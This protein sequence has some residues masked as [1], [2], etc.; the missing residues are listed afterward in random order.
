MKG[1]IING[2]R[3]GMIAAIMVASAGTALAQQNVH[4]PVPKKAPEIG[5]NGSV[6]FRIFAPNAKDVKLGGNLS[7]LVSRGMS[8]SDGTDEFIIDSLAPGLYD[9]WFE[10][11]GVKTLD[12]A[13]S[14]VARDIASLSNIFIVPGGK[15]DYFLSSDVPHGN[16][17]K[18]WYHSPTLG[19]DRRMTIYTPAGYETSDE[20]YPVLYLL[21]GMGGDEEAWLDLGRAVQI[22]DNMIAAGKAKPMIVVMPNGNALK[23]AAPGFTGEG[24]YM[25]AGE[26][27]ID[28]QRNFEKSFPEI[29]EYVE[30]NYRTLADKSHRAVAG[31]SMGG[32]HAWRL[33][34]EMPDEFDYVG[35][36]SPAV[37]WNGTGVGEADDPELEA[38]LKKQFATAPKAYV[39]AIGEED[40]LLPLN[41]T[42][43]QLLD[44]MGINYQY[45]PSTGGHEWKNWR[46]YL[47]DFLPLLF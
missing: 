30:K 34:L 2:I 38:K 39:I 15:A 43:R 5:E 36:F 37:R 41:D 1:N 47:V 20:A 46:N 11:D 17:H 23:P 31:L 16:V 28:P 9:Y 12:P 40:F 27:S 42:Y 19:A 7:G 24:M 25:P 18:V 8:S 3:I 14:Y 29:I 45:W 10:I 26:H 32:G 35:L 22:L 44:R 21:H 6:T 13:N 4:L 33:S